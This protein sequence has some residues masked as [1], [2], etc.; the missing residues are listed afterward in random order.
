VLIIGAGVG[1]FVGSELGDNERL[2]IAVLVMGGGVDGS[3][4]KLGT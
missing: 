3:F 4:E 2:G 1:S